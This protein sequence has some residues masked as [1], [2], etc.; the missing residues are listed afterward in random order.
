MHGE[1]MVSC[2]RG[3][4]SATA[5]TGVPTRSCRERRSSRERRSPASLGDPTG[6]SGKAR[7]RWW[8]NDKHVLVPAST[9]PPARGVPLTS[10]RTEPSS[11]I[12][13]RMKA[14]W[15]ACQERSGRSA[16]AAAPSR[17][18][19]ARNGFEE[20]RGGLTSG[21]RSAQRRHGRRSSPGG[22]MYPSRRDQR[23][24]RRW[25]RS[26]ARS[27]AG[28]G[29]S[30]PTVLAHDQR[31]IAPFVGVVDLVPVDEAGQVRRVPS[32]ASPP[33]VTG[34]RRHGRVR[35][36]G[37]L[38]VVLDGV[39]ALGSRRGDQAITADDPPPPP[40]SALGPGGAAVTP[41]GEVV[42][43]QVTSTGDPLAAVSRF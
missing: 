12:G 14:R 43:A 42:R 41:W 9:R 3:Q 21:P 25:G 40:T 38:D 2:A 17:K 23:A 35:S 39:D 32:S 13:L 22:A 29:E 20:E 8:T 1:T 26:T 7:W 36:R 34:Q 19:G 24:H 16:P 33:R 6:L 10:R 27:K 4:R 5:G 28:S 18:S 37:G 30:A 15:T 11:W 31:D